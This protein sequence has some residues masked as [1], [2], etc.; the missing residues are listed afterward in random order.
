MTNILQAVVSFIGRW[1]EG[2][3]RWL[4]DLMDDADSIWDVSDPLLSGD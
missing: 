3:S 1:V 4:T 2:P